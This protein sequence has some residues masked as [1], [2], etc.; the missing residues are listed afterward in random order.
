MTG[1]DQV[2]AKYR[3]DVQFTEALLEKARAEL[4]IVQEWRHALRLRV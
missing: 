1:L 3:L 4:R 2:E